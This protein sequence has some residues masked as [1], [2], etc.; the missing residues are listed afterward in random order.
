MEVENHF[1]SNKNIRDMHL[2]IGII[3]IH[4]YDTWI[5]NYHRSK[6]NMEDT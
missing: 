3:Y 4:H 2:R 5:H 1:E 6:H